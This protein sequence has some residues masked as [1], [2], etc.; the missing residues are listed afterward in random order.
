MGQKEEEA[1]IDSTD[2]NYD[3]VFKDA[4]SLFS[5]KSLEFLGINGLPPLG[6]P[7]KTELPDI[8]AHTA[9][10]DLTYDIPGL[11]G[12]HLDAEDKISTDDLIRFCEYVLRLIKAYKM[13]FMSIIFTRHKPSATKLNFKA[14]KFKP[15]IVCLADRDAD[16]TLARLKEEIKNSGQ[17][18]ELELIYLP[19]YASKNLNVTELLM[20]SAALVRQLDIPDVMAD[21]ILAM[22][23]VLANKLVDKNSLDNIW[24]EFSRMYKLKV[25]EVAEEQGMRKGVRKGVR[26]GMRKGVQKYREV[27]TNMLSNGASYEFVMKV[28][29]LSEEKLAE[30]E[31][32]ASKD[33]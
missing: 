14:L 27:V 22:M 21:K 12:V 23:L 2:K 9:F 4:L 16:K 31:R 26:K 3:I 29:G 20:E 6:K 10:S 1:L 17:V 18:N 5:G 32:K 33:V 11:G 7:L 25:L 8:S 13:D 19:L 15:I 28:T 24:K 30:L